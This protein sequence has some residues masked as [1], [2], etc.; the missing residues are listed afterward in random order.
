M[1]HR[2]LRFSIIYGCMKRE[3]RHYLSL[4]SVT[5]YFP[6]SSLDGFLCVSGYTLIPPASEKE[7]V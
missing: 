4:M 5:N 3:L 7:Y 2:N 1:L 6:V